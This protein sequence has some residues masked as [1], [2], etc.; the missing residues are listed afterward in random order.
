MKD[1]DQS[2]NPIDRAGD[3]FCDALEIE[4]VEE[5]NCYVERMCA[6]DEAML[7]Q[8]HELLFGKAGADKYFQEGCPTHISAEDCADSLLT[9][10]TFREATRAL[11]PPER[12]IGQCIGPYRLL[13]KIGSGGGGNVYLAEQERPLHRQVALKVLRFGTD[14]QSV[15]DRFEAERQVLAMMDHPNIANVLGAGA[16]EDDLPYFIMELVDGVKITDYCDS[17]RLD[18]VQRLELF[19]QVCHAIQHAHQKGII[20]RDIKPSN[21][22]IAIHDGIP[23]PKVIDFGVAKTIAGPLPLDHTIQTMCE[24]FVGTPAYM[25][26]EQAGLGGVDVDVRSDI[27]SLGVL[28]YELLTGKQPF[29]RKEMDNT[30]LEEMFRILREREPLRPSIRLMALEPEALSKIAHSRRI[31]PRRLNALLNGDLDWIVMKALE[32]DRE[33]RYQAVSGLAEDV[34]HYLNH[35]PVIARPPSR[36]YRFRKLVRRNKGVFA[37]VSAIAIAL[38]AGFGTSSWLYLKE[39]E[40]LREKAM[41]LAEAEVREKIAQA[42]VLLR[43][44]RPEEADQLVGTSPVPTVKPSL[45]AAEVFRSLS[46]WNVAQGRWKQAADRSSKLVQANKVDKTDMSL[47]ATSDLLWVAPMMVA[48]GDFE[49]YHQI[50]SE[51]LVR[52]GGTKDLIAAEQLIKISVIIP[53]N[54]ATVQSLKPLAEILFASMDNPSDTPPKDAAWRSFALACLEYRMGNYEQSV[55]WGEQC[56]SYAY[57]SKSKNAMT[58][59]VLAMAH[60]QL[61]HFETAHAEFETGSRAV[62]EQFPDGLGPI[63]D[64][65]N[66]ESGKWYDWINAYILMNEADELQHM[67]LAL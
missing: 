14:T 12:E 28:L 27:Y 51:S 35:E 4:S 17:Y 67:S 30:G 53:G 29:N 41:L 24:Q 36:R 13:K 31:E 38:I 8:V 50:V 3:I 59:L 55:A 52:L 66:E 64:Q 60:Y 25:S 33:R 21:I 48:A 20:H 19:I 15:I 5:R 39:K 58:H 49:N 54:D 65:G 57:A 2:L 44:N 45:E 7:A 42:A 6:G 9:D 46:L 61:S 63:R 47:A 32:K 34:R 1:D 37:S 11:L 23:A 16:T 62:K 56:L 43:K 10:P 18:I 22:L 40:L 26:P